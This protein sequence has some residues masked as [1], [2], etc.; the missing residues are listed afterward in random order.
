MVGRSFSL[1]RKIV[2]P[3]RFVLVIDGHF[4]LTAL[5]RVNFST[6]IINHRSYVLVKFLRDRSLDMVTTLQC[7]KYNWKI[8]GGRTFLTSAMDQTIERTDYL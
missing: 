4:Y 8:E 7:P 1:V 5:F 2:R 6:Y 3:I